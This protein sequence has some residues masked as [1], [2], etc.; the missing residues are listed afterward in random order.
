VS[1]RIGDTV[2]FI[3]DDNEDLADAISKMLAT[4]GYLT[5]PF[6]TAAAAIDALRH[7]IPD[8]IITD[9]SMSVMDGLTLATHMIRK[10]PDCK[11]IVVSGNP[12]AMG[13]HPHRHHFTVLQKPVSLSVMLEALQREMGSDGVVVAEQKK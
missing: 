10:N 8:F 1:T 7:T 9:F 2:G 5:T 11:V 4:Q 6:Y 3:V 13:G 12:E